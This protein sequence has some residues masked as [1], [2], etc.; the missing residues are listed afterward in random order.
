VIVGDGAGEK[1]DERG[2]FFGRLVKVRHNP[3]MGSRS[4]VANP[5]RG[6]ID[7][8]VSIQPT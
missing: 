1:G 8:K 4:P 3:D 6:T 7:L 5:R 2:G